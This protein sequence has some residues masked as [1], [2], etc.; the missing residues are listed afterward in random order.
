MSCVIYL[1]VM[2]ELVTSELCDIFAGERA[3]NQ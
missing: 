3:G 1:Q 2:K